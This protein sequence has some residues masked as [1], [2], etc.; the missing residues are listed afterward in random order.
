MNNDWVGVFTTP[1][2]HK[3]EIA[4]AILNENEIN[5]VIVNRKDSAY[6]FGELEVYVNGDDVLRAKL[7]LERGNI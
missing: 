4:K 5:S 3:A 1:Y 2:E 7:I 6:L